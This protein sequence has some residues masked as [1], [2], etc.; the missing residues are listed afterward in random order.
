MSTKHPK[1]NTPFPA[2][3]WD[4]D[5]KF[6]ATNRVEQMKKESGDLP[7]QPPDNPV[8]DDTPFKNLR[9]S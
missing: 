9:S 7:D 3:P 2:Y 1:E 8:R 5:G 6:P 4:S